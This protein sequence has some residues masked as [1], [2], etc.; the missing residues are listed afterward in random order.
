ME[1]DHVRHTTEEREV[2]GLGV[3]TLSET[4]LQEGPKRVT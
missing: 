3:G 4:D 2:I 1:Q